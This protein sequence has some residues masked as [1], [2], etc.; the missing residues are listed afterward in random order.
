V[1]IAGGW[2]DVVYVTTV[3][4]SVY[5]FDAND[6]SA[7][8]PLWHVNFGTPAGVRDADFTCTDINGNMGIVGTPVINAEKTVLYVVALTK[9]GG[10]FS[11]RLHALDLATGA[12]LPTARQRSRRLIS[13]P[14][15]RTSVRAF[16]FLEEMYI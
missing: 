15:G 9:A 12:D 14:S 10:H 4:N 6:A 13:I 3:N 2:H 1:K 7:I 16:S 11:Q 5:A 8:A